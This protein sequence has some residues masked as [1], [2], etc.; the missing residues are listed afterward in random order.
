M[1]VLAANLVGALTVEWVLGNTA[2]FPPEVRNAFA[3]IGRV[4]K[5]EDSANGSTQTSMAIRVIGIGGFS[6]V[7]A[8]AVDA[9]RL[10]LHRSRADR[11]CTRRRFPGSGAQSCASDFVA[12]SAE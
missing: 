6:H 5:R 11:Q 7:V 12:I 8:G 9:S 1:V 4:S 10:W 2:V 3:E